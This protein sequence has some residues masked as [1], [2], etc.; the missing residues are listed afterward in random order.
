VECV[1]IIHER[2][3][4]L[5]NCTLEW[6]LNLCEGL[7]PTEWIVPPFSLQPYIE[8]SIVWGIDCKEK[9]EGS[10]HVSIHETE[11]HLQIELKDDGIGIEE[12][13]KLHPNRERKI[14]ESGAYIVRQ[15][16]ALLKSLGFDIQLNISSNHHG[17][18][19]RFTY[20]KV[21]A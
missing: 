20:P 7:D 13:L 12:A 10:I 9:K 5:H 16:L 1:R 19:V 2:T 4:V 3:K 14:E 6:R 11:T 8:N 18:I 17:T 15:R 21:K